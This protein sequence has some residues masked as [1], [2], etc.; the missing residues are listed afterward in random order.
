MRTIILLLTIVITSCKISPTPID[1]PLEIPPPGAC[2]D[3]VVYGLLMKRE[4][5]YRK[6][7][8]SQ[9]NRVNSPE[10]QSGSHIAGM[11]HVFTSFLDGMENRKIAD[12]LEI[13]ERKV[14]AC[15]I[16]RNLNYK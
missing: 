5:L 1:T 15:S 13:I 16:R 3:Y 2:T 14:Y 7:A 4:K 11:I 10:L 6:Q 9:A 12:E 8:N